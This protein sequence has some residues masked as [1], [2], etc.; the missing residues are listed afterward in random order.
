MSRVANAA[1]TIPEGVEIKFDGQ[2]FSAKSKTG[3]LSYSIHSDIELDIQDNIVQVKWDDQV[4]K[5]KAQAGTTRANLNNIVV[6]LTAG[7]EKKLTLIGVGYRAQVKGKILT[8]SL[9]YSNPIEFVIP[10]GITIEAPSQTELVVK[11]INKQQVGQTASE[12]RDLRPPE[13]YKGKG[14]RYS[15]E[16]V[17]RKEAKKK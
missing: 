5:S 6:G 12:I 11:G 16:Q 8:L 14:V 3:E 7:F 15:D 4:K 17:V 9:G 10:D 1:V 2:L 13:P